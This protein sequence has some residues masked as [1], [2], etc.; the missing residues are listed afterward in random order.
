MTTT[1][2]GLDTILSSIAGESDEI[3]NKIISDAK[4]EAKA[5]IESAEKKAADLKNTAVNKSEMI[6]ND[7]MER[8]KNALEHDEKQKILSEK[9]RILSASI[10]DAV[11]K[12]KKLDDKA[13][14][15]FMESLI[16]K[17]VTDTENAGILYMNQ[18]DIKRMT[19]GFKKML[20]DRYRNIKINS[21]NSIDAGF[22]I[23]YGDID[24]N[25]TIDAIVEAELD[26]IKSRVNQVLF[27]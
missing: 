25:C 7:T 21:D 8:E 1:V 26:N 17:Y 18:N 22:R 24:D 3:V 11:D 16:T 13:Y 15:D 19:D 2:G 4:S 14:F 12:I 10:T 5:I 6:F 20:K 27:A 9:Q 23:K